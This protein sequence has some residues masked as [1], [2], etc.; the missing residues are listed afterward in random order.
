MKL[1]SPLL[2]LLLNISAFSQVITIDAKFDD[3]NRIPVQTDATGDASNLDLLEFAV[4]HD[5]DYLYL[6]VKTAEEFGLMNPPYTN[7]QIH[8]YIDTDNDATTGRGGNA[9][10]SELRILCGDKSIDFDYPQMGSYSGNL[11]TIGFQAGPTVTGK[12]FEMAIRRDAK[13][14]GVN[15]LFRDS[16]INLHFW[17]SAG[18]FMPEVNTS[19]SYT[20]DA[21]PFP[22]YPSID[23]VKSDPQHLRLMS[24][25]VLRGGLIDRVRGDSH[26]RIVNAMEPQII[27]FTEANGSASDVKKLL[28]VWYPIPGGWYT[29]LIRTNLVASQFPILFTEA[30]Y[31]GDNRAIAA[32]ID[33]PDNTYA[34]DI[35]VITSHPTCCSNDVARQEQIDRVASYILDAK[36]PGGR[37]NIP[38]NT[39][40]SIIGD[41]NLVG[42]SQQLKTIIEGDIVNTGTYGQGNP[43]DWD[44]S[45]MDNASCLHVEKP[46]FFTWRSPTSSF[47]PGKLD[48]VLYTGS[49][50]EEMNSFTLDTDELPAATLSQFG[51]NRNDTDVASD[52]LPLFADFKLE[53]TT[54]IEEPIS[55][56]SI[57]PNPTSDIIQIEHANFQLTTGELIDLHGKVLMRF[58][59]TNANHQLNISE[60]PAGMYVLVLT[61]KGKKF[62]EKLLKK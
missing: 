43:L 49:V 33:L 51:L 41:F 25:N 47:G 35:L 42:W 8:L 22:I 14:D 19:F 50:M 46:A 37:V 30:V 1:L 55:P 27:G 59:M 36:S 45:D 26:E 23:M 38:F 7:S 58:E 48:Y 15:N 29:D 24:Y 6:R 17:S 31:P 57:Y 60:L 9:L 18:D 3:W 20:F 13:P 12:E 56:F 11:Y 2:L 4:T 40:I 54:G 52:H 28:D 53:V 10:G 5:A 62:H 44:G 21:G 32:F 34:T 39:P 61:H 16:T